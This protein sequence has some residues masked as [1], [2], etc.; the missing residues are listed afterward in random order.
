MSIGRYIRDN[1]ILLVKKLRRTLLF[2]E[3]FRFPCVLN[4]FNKGEAFFDLLFYFCL[5]KSN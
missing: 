4:F 1:S 2:I 3:K 5:D